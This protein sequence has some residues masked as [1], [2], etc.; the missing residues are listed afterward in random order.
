MMRKTSLMAFASAC[1]LNNAVLK[2][3]DLQ[4]LDPEPKHKSSQIVSAMI[5]LSTGVIAI[6]RS[7]SDIVLSQNR[8]QRFS[9][10]ATTS[11]YCSLEH[12]L[13]T[14]FSGSQEYHRLT[15]K[16]PLRRFCETSLLW[17]AILFHII[18]K[19]HVHCN[20]NKIS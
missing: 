1:R 13:P 20:I 14:T 3:F 4:S 7:P 11:T 12:F 2:Q 18:G 19:N 8:S 17:T 6:N 5:H 15:K 16:G 9:N 10:C